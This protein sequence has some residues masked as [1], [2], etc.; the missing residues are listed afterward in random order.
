[1]ICNSQ[2]F[3]NTL[4][5]FEIILQS[6]AVF[7][8]NFCDFCCFTSTI[9]GHICHVF[10]SKCPK[11][12]PNWF[13]LYKKWKFLPK[14]SKTYFKILLPLFNYFINQKMAPFALINTPF[15]ARIFKTILA[16]LNYSRA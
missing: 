8:K 2:N 10:I 15:D 1:M 6:L 3:D 13:Y 16:G 5:Y 14:L 11:L 7:Y 12:L 4:H 9:S